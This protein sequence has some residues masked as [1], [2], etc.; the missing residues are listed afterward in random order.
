MGYE[1]DFVLLNILQSMKQLERVDE[2]QRNLDLAENID[3]LLQ[4]SLLR[5]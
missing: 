4:V 5:D 2:M 1:R 3:E